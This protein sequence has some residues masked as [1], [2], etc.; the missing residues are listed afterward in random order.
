MWGYF[1]YEISAFSRDRILVCADIEYDG[2]CI[3]LLFYIAE[4]RLKN[5]EFDE[6]DSCHRRRA[7]V[8]IFAGGVAG[9][10]GV[11]EHIEESSK[12]I[13]QSAYSADK[14]LD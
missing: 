10:F 5:F 8:E 11:G 1:F 13:P 9:Q 6:F 12:T 14:S 2:K 7:V 4:V 3:Q